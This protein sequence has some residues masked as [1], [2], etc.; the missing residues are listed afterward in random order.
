MPIYILI[1]G[2]PYIQW[3]WKSTIWFLYEWNVNRKI[4]NVITDA[5]FD[6][7]VKTQLTCRLQERVSSL[8]KNLKN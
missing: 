6:F 7:S 3:Q 4:V 8:G 1:A 5:H 2:L